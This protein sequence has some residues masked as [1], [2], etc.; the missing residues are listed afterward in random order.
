MEFR[1]WFLVIVGFVVCFYSVKVEVGG[2]FISDEY[3]VGLW[4]DNFV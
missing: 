4:K 3:L 2:L 1:D